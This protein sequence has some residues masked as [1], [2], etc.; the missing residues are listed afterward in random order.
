MG[1][2]RSIILLTKTFPFAS[3]E[4]FLEDEIASLADTFPNVYI[5]A[6]AVPEGAGKTRTLPQ[7]VKCF[8]FYETADRRLKYAKYT[9]KGI[10]SI[11]EREVRSEFKGKSAKGRLGAVYISGRSRELANKI[12]N[13]PG[14]KRVLQSADTIL[15]SY[16]FLD[17]PYLSVL[18]KK[19]LE[20][21]RL[22]IVSRAHGYDL[23]EYRNAGG[24]IPFRR[25]VMQ[26]IEKVF[27]CSRDGQ[28][29][30]RERFPEY[31]EKIDVSYLG[32][33][34]CGMAERAENGGFHLATCSAIIPL[35]RLDLLA[36]A[37]KLC[38]EKGH[39]FKWTC[40][41]EGPLLPGLQK[42]VK[43]NL[44]K[45]T[46]VFTG[47]LEHADALDYLKSNSIDLFVSVSET[48]GLP[49]SIMEA[50]SFGIPTLATDVG[51]T[52]E[53][54]I[55]ELTGELLPKDVS[56]EELADKL[57]EC[58]KTARSRGQIR[59]YWEEHFDRDKNYRAFCEK[60]ISI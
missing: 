9:V 43:S 32:T 59:A 20:N 56:R 40:I 12:L 4:E 6:T 49:V 19:Q 17:L 36:G 22:K 47:R 13:I 38:E 25:I 3:G 44:K 28:Q 11:F 26:N 24:Y 50:I 48:E 34:D 37:L 15:Y 30:L 35:K 1:K 53:I 58:S 39:A 51:G 54:V 23:Y 29:Y 27:P 8:E 55:P 42:Y 52:R 5:I 7:N 33:K 21:N 14:I 2:D 16:W 46:V 41:G 57:I 18:L 10:K 60:L 31:S 45:C